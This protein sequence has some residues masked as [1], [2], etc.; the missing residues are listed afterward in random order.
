MSVELSLVIPAWNESGRLPSYLASIRTYLGGASLSGYEVIVVDDGSTDGLAD[1][2]SRHARRWPELS[3]LRH[4]VNRGKGAAVRTGI[5]AASGRYLLFTD[6]DGATP[7]AEESR[8]RAAIDGGADL[9]A[10][11]RM[12]SWHGGERQRPWLRRTIGRAF[13]RLVHAMLSVPIRDTQ[14]GFKMF[15]QGVGHHL[16]GATTEDGYLFDIEIL[17]LALRCRYQVAEV[18]VRWSEVPGSKVDLLR[19]SCRMAMGLSRVRRAVGAAS[20]GMASAPPCTDCLGVVPRLD[21]EPSERGLAELSAAI[22]E[23]SPVQLP[24]GAR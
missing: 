3:V 5:L 14:C 18:P 17:A 16:L 11:S 9:A 12:V 20:R 21:R 10:G 24:A 8:L 22:A 15:R 2:I 23:P 19:D 1:R 7:I 4:P 6:A 13:V